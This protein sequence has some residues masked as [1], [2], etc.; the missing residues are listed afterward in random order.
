MIDGA[1]MV[2]SSGE[3]RT[4]SSASALERKNRV[5]WKLVAPRALKKTNRSN[6]GLLG[7]RDQAMGAERGDLLDPPRRLVAHRGGE[8]DD[9]V[10]A[11]NGVAQ[12]ARVAEVGERELDPHPLGTEAPRVADQAADLV[13]FLE[14]HRQQRRAH[15]AGPSGE[16]NHRRE[17][18][19]R[20]AG[21]ILS[22]VPGP[23]NV[24]LR[25]S[26]RGAAPL[27]SIERE[28]TET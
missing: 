28:G 12:A 3:V 18:Y 20:P 24:A 22:R 17:P 4:R 14:Q 23:Y 15:D 6:P 8:V 2:V 10:D 13:S 16:Q 27:R 9:G 11:A 1:K 5:R 7:R 25:R 19:P 21:A 26:G